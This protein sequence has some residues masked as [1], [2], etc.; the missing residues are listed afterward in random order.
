MRGAARRVRWR[1]SASGRFPSVSTARYPAC[2]RH[3]NSTLRITIAW[4]ALA[5]ESGPWN[6]RQR[7]SPRGCLRPP[8]ATQ[9][10]AGCGS[11][12]NCWRMGQP[13]QAVLMRERRQRLARFHPRPGQPPPG[14]PAVIPEGGPPVGK[15]RIS[16]PQHHAR[17]AS[18]SFAAAIC[19]GPSDAR[20]EPARPSGAAGR[21]TQ[22]SV[23]GGAGCSATR[24]LGLPDDG[25][26]MVDDKGEL[27]RER[28]G[29]PGAGRAPIRPQNR[30]P[31]TH[32]HD[33]DITGLMSN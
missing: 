5:A 24:R 26:D 28:C 14:L 30:D 17:I 2:T 6:G 29:L 33:I 7:A 4:R 16:P 32:R 11:A 8:P 27:F 31:G 12:R 20:F 13:R 19:A 18:R 9:S 21:Q 1:A 25:F 3:E 23:P 10:A 15:A 22:A